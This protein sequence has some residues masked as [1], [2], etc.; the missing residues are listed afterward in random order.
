MPLQSRATICYNARDNK[1][2]FTGAS[3][4]LEHLDVSKA[5]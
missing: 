5:K 3:T 4:M 1:K 2:G